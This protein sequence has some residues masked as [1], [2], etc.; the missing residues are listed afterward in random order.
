[1]RFID[2]VDKSFK[3]VEQVRVGLS[4]DKKDAWEFICVELDAL[5]LRACDPLKP[6]VEALL[7]FLG[8]ASIAFK[9]VLVAATDEPSKVRLA[10]EIMS[11]L[12]YGY[13]RLEFFVPPEFMVDM[14]IYLYCQAREFMRHRV[15]AHFS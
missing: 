5:K 12:R 9:Y 14:S 1:M 4:L 6:D 13:L 15:R 10:I 8:L 3:R 7:D 2:L 11:I